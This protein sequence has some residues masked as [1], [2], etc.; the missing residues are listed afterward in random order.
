MF[1]RVINDQ[2]W[3]CGDDSVIIM[4]DDVINLRTVRT[5]A[6][7]DMGPLRDVALLRDGEVVF[8]TSCGLFH[9]H[10]DGKSP[11]LDTYAQLTSNRE[12]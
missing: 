3:C 1:I 4:R 8:A 5:I 10:T 6:A 7:G 11:L 9:A 2:L 12:I